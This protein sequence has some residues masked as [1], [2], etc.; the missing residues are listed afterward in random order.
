MPAR[1]R[2]A[3]SY[4]NVMST[5]AVF[6]V[7]GGGAYAATK[8]PKNSV[9]GAQ[10]KKNAVTGAKV[11]N[12]SL[13]KGDF[14]KGQIKSGANGRTGAA[15]SKGDPGVQGPPGGTGSQG[16]TGPAGP[17]GDS[18]PTG[19]SLGRDARGSNVANLDDAAPGSTLVTLPVFL[20]NIVLG[21][22]VIAN[23]TANTAT[24]S[25]VL[26]ATT[27]ASPPLD[28]IDVVLLPGSSQTVTLTGMVV[29]ASNTMEMA[30]SDAGKDLTAQKPAL[31]AIQFDHV[32]ASS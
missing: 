6:G 15:G 7:L 20:N 19:F 22:A 27:S 23:T 25:C 24:A 17:K 28:S 2:G 10:I 12:G 8:L 9:G 16:V 4:A 18:G 21:R 32:G 1:L 11:K 13:L 31:T 30:C 29:N 14:K 5:I 3:L 26:Q